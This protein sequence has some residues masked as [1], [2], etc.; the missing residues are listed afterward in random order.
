LT[1]PRHLATSDA[2]DQ[3]FSREGA[4]V[5]VLKT[6]LAAFTWHSLKRMPALPAEFWSK[7]G[8]RWRHNPGFVAAAAAGSL[9]LVLAIV[10]GIQGAFRLLDGEPAADDPTDSSSSMA[11]GDPAD[12]FASTQ[13]ERFDPWDEPGAMA[14]RTAARSGRK[15]RVLDQFDN[16][17][18]DETETTSGAPKKL[19]ARDARTQKQ[20]PFAMDDEQEAEEQPVSLKPRSRHPLNENPPADEVEHPRKTVQFP[21]AV[22]DAKETDDADIESA[23]VTAKSPAN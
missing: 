15:V 8:D 10:L 9:G 18:D 12:G 22:D 21:V 2:T 20:D 5:L 19:A 1:E 14:D 13:G 3:G 17:L 11:L 6:I 23:K 4:A 7:F 16:E